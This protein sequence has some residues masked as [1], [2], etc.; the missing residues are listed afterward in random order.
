MR[1]QIVFATFLLSTCY[2]FG[3]NGFGQETEKPFTKQEILRLLTT[4]PGTRYEQGNLA[5]EIV[6]RGI[7]FPADE[8]GLPSPDSPSTATEEAQRDAPKI[9]V[10]KLPLLDQARNHAAEFMDDLP[11][12]VVTQIVTR[13][14]RTAKKK[15]WQQQDKL[16]I[17]VS[18]RAKTGE[19][20]KLVRYNDKTTQMTYD[21]LKGATTAGEFGSILGALFSPQSQAEFKEVRRETFHGHQTVIYDFRVSKEFSSNTITDFN[22]GRTVTTAYSGRVWIDTESGRTLRIEQSADDIQPGFPIT[23]AKRSVEYDWIIID[24]QRY[25]LPVYAEVIL[26]NDLKRYYLRNV[27][28]LRNYRM[29]DTDLKI[30]PEK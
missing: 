20:F 4:T 25:L 23:S 19:Q 30:L 27:I 28:E 5:G 10:A 29:F 24:R 11:N 22:S 3:G 1:K 2:V 21:Q 8:K 26:G 15:D 13:S 14:V 6:Q 18:Y 7:D 17:E 16:E 9:D 12:F